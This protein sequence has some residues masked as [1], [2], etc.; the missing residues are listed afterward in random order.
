MRNDELSR[1]CQHGEANAIFDED[2]ARMSGVEDH[3]FARTGNN[4]PRAAG[5]FR[6]PVEDRL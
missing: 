3:H 1:K 4:A 6:F 2:V 5:I